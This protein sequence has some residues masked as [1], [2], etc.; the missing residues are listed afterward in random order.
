M[1]ISFPLSMPT[2]RGLRSLT[3]QPTSMVGVSM[4]PFTFAQ[5]TYVHPGEM[6]AGSFELGEMNRD[7]GEEWAAFLT[8]LRGR[9]GTF[10]LG[11]PLGATPRGTW[12]APLVN[13][14]SQTGYVMNIDGM[15]AG[16]TGKKGDWFQIG[17]GSSTQL[18]KLTLD[19]TANG[20]GQASI[21]F[22]PA[23]RTSPADNAPLTLTSA[24]GIFRL[25]HNMRSWSLQDVR[26]SGISIDFHE[27]R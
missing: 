25:S 23:L 18:Y 8:S 9:E 4:S 14:G 15:S 5:Q 21:D 2:G 17:S 22:W 13:L 20:S 27:A 10:L 12:T 16:A 7:D 1:T 3:I 24:K 11:D 19:F 6:F 26:L